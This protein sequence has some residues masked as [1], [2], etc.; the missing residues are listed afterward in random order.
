MVAADEWQ[1]MFLRGEWLLDDGS[2]FLH[3]WRI[4]RDDDGE[5]ERSR[6]TAAEQLASGM[7]YNKETFVSNFDLSIR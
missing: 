6:K 3:I 1:Y 5:V 7:E 2:L 4:R